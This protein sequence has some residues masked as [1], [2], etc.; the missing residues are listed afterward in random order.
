MIE[1]CN[2]QFPNGLPKSF[3]I[4]I[5]TQRSNSC[6]QA[7]GQKCGHQDRFFRLAGEVVG[8]KEEGR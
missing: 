7:S 4:Y 8:I 2:E 5:S 1:S 3:V 6:S